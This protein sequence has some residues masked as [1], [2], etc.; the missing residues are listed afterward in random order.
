[1]SAITASL[2]KEL[3]TRTGAGMMDCKKALS[4]NDGDLEKSIDWLRQK[5]LAAAA[6]KAGR[7]AAE[8]LIAVKSL[9]TKGV[10]V[11]VNAETDFVSRNEKFQD[12]VGQVANIALGI[13]N[14]IEAL[15]EAAYEKTERTV[16]AELTH[17]ISVIGENMNLRR[18]ES[19][20]VSEGVVSTYVH[21]AIQDGIGRIGTMVALESAGDADKLNAVG[22]Q[23]AMHV[24][25][26]NP[27]SCH[28]ADLDADALAKERAVLTA[29]AKESGKP[30]EVVEKMVEGRIRKYYEEVV[31][32]EQI[33]M[34][35][36]TKRKVS[37]VVE[38]LAK[39]IGT[40]VKLAGYVHFKL[41]EGVEKKESDFAAE[42]AE[43]L[44]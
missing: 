32:A 14:D 5:G 8:G 24:A 10:A 1:M 19:V 13:S 22:K 23:I 44:K 15:K 7:A 41:G 27:Q 34:I 37:Q 38:D 4:E 28:I 29:Q 43:Q 2:V 35:D 33:F 21:S 30:D 12:Y 9:G 39:E 25:A 31:L 40:S 17:L 20:E 36:D 6:K 18:L 3:R 42:V 16:G 11:E 26:A